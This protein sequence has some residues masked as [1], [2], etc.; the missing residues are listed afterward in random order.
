MA[1]LLA[2]FSV[3]KNHVKLKV[4]QDAVSIDNM[5]FKLHYRVTFVAL[6]LCTLLVTSR[7]FIGEHI[8]CIIGDKWGD[9]QIKVIN[10]Y[11][12][13]MSTYTVPKYMNLTSAELGEI[14]HPG[15][16]PATKDD[17]VVHHAYYQWVPFV[18]FF[19]AILFYMPHY[20]WRRAEGGRLKVL[21]SGLQMAS[22]A[23]RET[24][25]K[26][27]N[28]ITI[29]SRGERDEKIRQIRQAFLQRIHLNR[30]W[31]YSLGL[32]EVLNFI[33]VLVQIYLTDWFLG[34]AF[35]GLGKVLGQ[36]S[37]DGKV[38]ALD[39]VFPKVTKCVFHKYGASGS[40]QNHDALCIMALNIVNEKIYVFLWYWFIILATV[41]G[42]GLIWRI[43][44]MILHARSVLFNKIVFSM[45]CPGKYNPWNVLAVT[46]E[47]HYGD[48]IF[49][50]YI[51]KN[52]DNYVFKELLQKLAQDLQERQLHAALTQEKEPLTGES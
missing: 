21:V 37:T 42:F 12:F 39:V 47:C 1:D 15:V 32:C 40:I 51:A 4:T 11:C 25:L 41:T 27:E 43:L 33:N 17:P 46:H 10:T 49:L 18:L 26:T 38:D 16:G 23:L 30:P 50:Y 20:I 24:S 7:Q 29:P 8:R 35:L 44:T 31:A 9:D 2:T 34:G 6:L 45:A 22:L 28:N 3:I 52:L 36:E 14:A 19:Q 13:F 48:W 5:V